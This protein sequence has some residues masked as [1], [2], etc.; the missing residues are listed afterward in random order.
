MKETL[1]SVY[2]NNRAKY[3]IRISERLECL[4]KEY[5][6]DESRI[7]RVSARAKSLES[8]MVKAKKRINGHLIYKT[9]LVEIQ[10]QIGARIIVSFKSDV[11]RIS[12]I[13]TKYFRSIEEKAVY[14]ENDSEFGYFGHHFILFLPSDVF[15][16]DEERERCPN[17]F[18]LQIKTLYQHA[19]SEANHDLG[20]KQSAKLTLD[21]KRK[22]AFTSA[23]SW[24]ADTI[25]DELYKSKCL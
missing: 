11:L 25:F 5:V 2:S 9:P 15:V 12:N 23:Q 1:Q 22:I 24:G 4:L 19:W 13:V 3:L 7:D 20:Y 14:P 6:A 17:M 18:E 8:F 21:E 16:S 10:D